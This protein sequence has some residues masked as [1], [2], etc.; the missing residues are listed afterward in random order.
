MKPVTPRT[1][2]ASRAAGVVGA[3]SRISARPPPA[4]RRSRSGSAPAGRSVSS[5]PDTPAACASSAKRSTPYAITGFT[6]VMI[7]TGIASRA[8]RTSVST[9]ATVI[10][11][12]SAVWVDRWMVGPSARGSL[13]GT[14]TSTKS[15]PARSAA[16][17][18]SREA[19]GVGY[20][21]VI[22]GIS[23][24]RRWARTARHRAA[25]GWSDKV[26]ADLDAVLRR[27][28]DLD[29]RPREL[30]GFLL[31]R[32]I[33]DR[34]RMH[35]RPVGRRHDPHHGPVHRGDVGVGR[36]HQGHLV[37]VENDAGAHPVDADE[38]DERLDDDRV[39]TAA[40]VLPHLLEHLVGLNRRRLVDAAAGGGVESVRHRDD[41]GIDRQLAGADRLGVSRQVRLHVMLVGDDHPAV[42]DFAVPAQPEQRQHAEPGVGLHDAPLFV[43]Q[44][45][46]L[47]QHFQRHARLAHVVEQGGDA[48]IVELQLGEAELAA[49]GDGEDAHV[50]GVRERV[51]VVVAQRGEPHQ[52]RLVVQYL[53]Y[54][55]LAGSLD[56]ADVGGAPQADAVDDLFR[57]RHRAGVGP[58][59]GLL[60]ALGFLDVFLG[61]E[62]RLDGNEGD[63]AV[64]ELLRQLEDLV[65]VRLP[66]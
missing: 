62:R 29:D 8:S 53:I 43:A 44:A 37:S 12:S 54:A 61:L 31:L 42:G 26:V 46:L 30:A 34:A 66:R 24:A 40:R 60:Q 48:E 11:W 16:R 65:G 13:N 38:D 5:S 39:V 21:A 10:P 49:Q 57:H 32:E 17:N 33:D 9:P 14:P 50:H 20:P 22:Y 36:L 52:R 2:S 56:H 55:R 28:A 59:R 15:A 64:L 63:A 4:A 3:T 51:L 23:A 35:Q 41:L 58:L 27:I 6:Y 18:A 7:T 1:A 25:I 19:A 47:V 45:A